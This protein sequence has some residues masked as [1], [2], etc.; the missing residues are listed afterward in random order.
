MWAVLI[1]WIG[2]AIICVTGHAFRAN[3]VSILVSNRVIPPTRVC[4][5]IGAIHTNR[6]IQ[7][8]GII[9][10]NRASHVV[11]TRIYHCGSR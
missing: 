6:E 8:K 9:P 3:R 1:I 7:T 2:L 10:A 4:P 11:W 5:T